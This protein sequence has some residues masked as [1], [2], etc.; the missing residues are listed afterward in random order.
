M[1]QTAPYPTDRS[2]TIINIA[3]KEQRA[4]CVELLITSDLL[5]TK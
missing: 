5:A 4:D 3:Q 2:Q 1:A